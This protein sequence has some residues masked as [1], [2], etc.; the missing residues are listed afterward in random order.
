V[1]RQP[2]NVPRQH[3]WLGHK[4]RRRGVD[5]LIGSECFEEGRSGAASKFVA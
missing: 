3:C 4:R 2:V 1:L 5:R